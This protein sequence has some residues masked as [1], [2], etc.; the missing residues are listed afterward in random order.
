MQ[1]S[2]HGFTGLIPLHDVDPGE[3]HRIEEFASGSVS[4]DEYLKKCAHDHY[5]EH[6]SSTSVIFHEDFP[7]LVGYVT[8]TNDAIRLDIAEVNHLGLSC[9]VEL[10]S[11]P[12]VKICRIAVHKELHGNKIGNRILDLVI[13]EIVGATGI[14][15]ARIIITDAINEPKVI[16]FYSKYGFLESIWSQGQVAQQKR[17][18]VQV[19][20]KMIRDLYA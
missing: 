18:T 1:L 8:L 12:A 14:S 4:L 17:G 20:I 5:E 16:E 11:F 3:I 7:G 9:H 19:T 15:A 2:E 6:L 13:G 10:T